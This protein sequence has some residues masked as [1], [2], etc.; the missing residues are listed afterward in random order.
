MK[1]SKEKQERKRGKERVLGMTR[2]V[3]IVGLY[4]LELPNLYVVRMMEYIG[5]ID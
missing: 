1:E 4:I 5:D 3:Y 2:H